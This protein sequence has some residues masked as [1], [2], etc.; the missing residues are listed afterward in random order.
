M[1]EVTGGHHKKPSGFKK[2]KRYGAKYFDCLPEDA[3]PDAEDDPEGEDQPAEKYPHDPT[4][5]EEEEGEDQPEDEE[6]DDHDLD[7]ADD[8]Q[9][10]EIFYQGMKAGKKLKS[11]SKGWTKP[12]RPGRPSSSTTSSSNVAGNKKTEKTGKCLDCG[13]FGHWKGDPECSRVKSGHT[14]LF[15]KHGVN[16]IH[17]VLDKDGT[18]NE[19]LTSITRLHEDEVIAWTVNCT[20]NFNEVIDWDPNNMDETDMDEINMN[21]ID[22]GEINITRLAIEDKNGDMDIQD[23]VNLEWTHRE[24]PSQG[25]I[26]PPMAPTPPRIVDL[27]D[28]IQTSTDIPH[29]DAYHEPPIDYPELTHEELDELHQRYEHPMIIEQINMMRQ[30]MM[31]SEDEDEVFP[32]T[33]EI[34]DDED[35]AD[36]WT[37]IADVVTEKH[38]IRNDMVKMFCPL[39]QQSDHTLVQCQDYLPDH[40]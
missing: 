16:V 8:E 32:E 38:L 18:D 7:G 9:L 23:D 4:D 34:N 30:L 1:V 20:D 27:D 28:I 21:D 37:S 40:Q 17:Y 36:P 14:P 33:A 31:D 3:L 15:K 10:W 13:Q 24:C 11:A 39:C 29:P 22:M 12:G 6:E 26:P 2:F 35:D 19:E 25:W 5:G